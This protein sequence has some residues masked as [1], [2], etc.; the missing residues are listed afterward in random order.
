LALPGAFGSLGMGGGTPLGSP[1]L[2]RL[3]VRSFVRYR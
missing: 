1:T 2:E 3:E